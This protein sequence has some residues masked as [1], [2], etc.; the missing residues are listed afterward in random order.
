MEAKLEQSEAKLEQSEAQP[1]RAKTFFGISKLMK[2]LDIPEDA[3]AIRVVFDEFVSGIGKF[4]S[5][6]SINV[7]AVKAIN[8]EQKIIKTYDMSDI[9]EIA[10]G[11]NVWL[12]AGKQLRKY[13]LKPEL[14]SKIEINIHPK[15]GTDNQ[16]K[17]FEYYPVINC[18]QFSKGEDIK[19]ALHKELEEQ[20]KDYKKRVQE[21]SLEA[22]IEDAGPVDESMV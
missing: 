22:Y 11:V 2:N 14:L 10:E 4:K 20:E 13:P 18:C 7:L 8:K 9:C 21:A 17:S 19:E 1:F 3:A 6:T 15:P 16:G 5:N 12:N